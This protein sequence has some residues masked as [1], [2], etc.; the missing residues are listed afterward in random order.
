MM[1]PFRKRKATAAP[2]S[3][4][5]LKQFLSKQKVSIPR[6]LKAA[7]ELKNFDYT[8]NQ[9]PG[10]TTVIDYLTSI[11]QGSSGNNRT[12]REIFVEHV[13]LV[14][15]ILLVCPSTSSV[16]LNQ[17]DT[18]RLE[19]VKDSQTKGTIF[20]SADLA[21]TSSPVYLY[22]VDNAKRFRHLYDTKIRSANNNFANASISTL[23]GNL[24]H[25]NRKIRVG[26]RIRYYNASNAGTVADCET[27]GIALVLSNLY[28][29][30]NFQ[31]TVRVW[32]RDV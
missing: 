30:A 26:S 15:Q 24:Y 28:G 27:G 18:Y 3:G 8:L 14:I 10:A 11:V 21:T 20:A 16:S 19:V 13:E 22:N 2:I 7:H 25:I 32:F 23:N 4:K 1:T 29:F 31:G 6:I 17:S 12:G 9:T 5:K